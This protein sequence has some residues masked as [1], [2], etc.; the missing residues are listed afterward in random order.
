MKALA[1]FEAQGVGEMRNTVAVLVNA[2]RRDVE[3]D[4]EALKEYIGQILFGPP[5][6]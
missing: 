3:A 5:V 6:A 4:G 1:E 2:M